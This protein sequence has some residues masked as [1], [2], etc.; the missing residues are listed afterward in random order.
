MRPTTP[1][2]SM[3]SSQG[4]TPLMP[5]RAMSAQLMAFT[6]PMTLRFT[7]GASTSP[8]TGSHTRPITFCRAM[9]QAAAICAPS[10]P[11]AYTSAAA[12]IAEAEPISA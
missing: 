6:A 1:M 11:M 10:P 2:A 7:Q 8:A 9:A 3:T 12:A 5:H 4:M